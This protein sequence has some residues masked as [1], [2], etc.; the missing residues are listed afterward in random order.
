MLMKL[1]EKL[2][3]DNGESLAE[4]LIAVLII[5]VGLVLLSSLIMAASHMM[6]TGQKTMEELYA[7]NN[8]IESQ[9]ATPVTGT[10]ELDIKTSD[11]QVYRVNVDLYEDETSGLKAYKIH[12][13]NQ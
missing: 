4:V 1:K 2:R 3:K 11:N 12:E 5:A 7:G 6:D 9:S 10:K 8:A 13:S